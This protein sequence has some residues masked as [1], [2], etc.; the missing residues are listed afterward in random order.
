MLLMLKV[1]IFKMARPHD[2]SGLIRVSHCKYF[3]E[4]AFYARARI[5]PKSTEISSD[6]R[7]RTPA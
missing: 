1:A 7:V 3:V 6:E 4:Y 2:H 5:D